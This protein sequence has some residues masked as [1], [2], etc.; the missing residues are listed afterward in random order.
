MHALRQNLNDILI[1]QCSALKVQ[2]ERCLSALT[3]S[4]QN[5]LSENLTFYFFMVMV[6]YTACNLI[7]KTFRNLFVLKKLRN[8]FH[9]LAWRS[10]SQLAVVYN[11]SEIENN[12][13]GAILKFNNQQL[14]ALLRSFWLLIENSFLPRRMLAIQ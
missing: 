3:Q 12:F 1:T 6:S 14:I 11:F 5:H 8:K 13:V 9:N 4:S 2:W 10:S 7:M